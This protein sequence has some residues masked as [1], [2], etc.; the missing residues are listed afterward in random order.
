VKPLPT[1]KPSDCTT[2]L[3]SLYGKRKVGGKDA[4][5]G[6]HFLTYRPSTAFQTHAFVGYSKLQIQQFVKKALQEQLKS[7]IGQHKSLAGQKYEGY[8]RYNPQMLNLIKKL[9]GL[10]VEVW[11]VSASPQAVLEVIAKPTGLPTSR[12]IG[13]RPL[14]DKNKL[15]TYGYKGC[16]GFPDGQS[17]LITYIQGKRCWINQ[18]IFGIKGADALK[19]APKEKRAI[20]GAGDADTDLSM[21]QDINGPRLI[22]NRNKNALMCYAYHN[23]DKN[24]W[25]HPTFI[26]PK[27]QKKAGYACDKT[28]CINAKGQKIPCIDMHGKTIPHQK[29]KTFSTIK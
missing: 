19:P 13:I 8:I 1:N 5:T 7:P 17:N 25:I 3:S 10:G 15:F 11:L 22:F 9:N 23:A 4:F 18:V 2:E 27:P 24:W 6:Y 21:M 28:A 26:A 16:G 14:F 29:D 20:F 12:M